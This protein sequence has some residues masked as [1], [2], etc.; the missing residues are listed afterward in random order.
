MDARLPADGV[1]PDA[2]Q[3]FRE[4]LDSLPLD[5]GMLP[6]WPSWWPDGVIE[7]LCPDVALRERFVDECPAVPRSMFST[8]VPAPPVDLPSAFLAFGEG[9]ADQSAIAEQR[10][11]PVAKLPLNHLAPMV[12]PGE[13]AAALAA[14]CE[15][16]GVW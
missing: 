8:P 15:S 6:P 4:L 13:V 10:G 16:L 1:A 2:E 14:L 11:W 9:Y 7:S 3:P 5:G 12:A